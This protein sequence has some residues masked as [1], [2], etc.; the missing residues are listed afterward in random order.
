MSLSP[1]KHQQWTS[2]ITQ[3]LSIEDDRY[4]DWQRQQQQQQER[5][6]RQPDPAAD[7]RGH[8]R[9]VPEVRPAS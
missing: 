2:Q 9:G 8:S 7:P 1:R 5:Q 6:Y 4:S 3:I